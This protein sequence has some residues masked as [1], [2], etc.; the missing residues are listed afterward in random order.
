MK[1]K[2]TP[3]KK[4][5]KHTPTPPET[6]R[7]PGAPKEQGPNDPANYDEAPRENLAAAALA[8]HEAVKSNTQRIVDTPESSSTLL[9]LAKDLDGH[10]HTT[11]GFISQAAYETVRKQYPELGFPEH[12]KL[13]LLEK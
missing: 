10:V 5:D 4:Q 9:V 13:P 6:Y 1:Q 2:P 12:S 8:E 3:P 7:E 11:K